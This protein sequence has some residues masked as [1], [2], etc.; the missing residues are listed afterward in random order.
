MN[1]T[2]SKQKD[3]LEKRLDRL[4]DKSYNN[5]TLLD[6]PVTN[7]KRQISLRGNIPKLEI[8]RKLPKPLEPTKYKPTIPKLRLKKPRIKPKTQLKQKP[9]PKP[10]SKMPV[11]LPRTKIITNAKALGRAVQTHEVSIMD[12]IRSSQTIRIYK[13]SCS[14]LF[15][16]YF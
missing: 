7:Y 4:L 6:T 12:K 14:Y 1:I 11:A 9:I 3:S 10:R 16:K 15:T 13:T 2:R 8:I 5:N